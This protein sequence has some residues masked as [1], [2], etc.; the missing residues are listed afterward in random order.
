VTDLKRRIEYPTVARLAVARKLTHEMMAE[1]LRILYVAMTRAREKLII[2]S[3]FANA[4]R[5]LIRL[6]KD[7]SAPVPPRF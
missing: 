6:Q 2:V 7:A 5:E 3:T 4:D 1:E